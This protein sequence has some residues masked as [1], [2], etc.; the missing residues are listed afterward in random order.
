MCLATF[1]SF[2]CPS[3][4]LLGTQCFLL[5]VGWPDHA[6]IGL[7]SLKLSW[8][9]C[10]LSP[11]SIKRKILIRMTCED[12]DIWPLK[13]RPGML[14]SYTS[15]DIFKNYS[16]VFLLLHWTTFIFS[17]LP[18]IIFIRP[19]KGVVLTIQYPQFLYW[20]SRLNYILFFS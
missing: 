15:Q 9:Q 12:P 17:L 3:L 2:S 19:D 14:I 11:A 18:L 13:D 4:T 8:S 20:K 5:M 7:S 1:C 16:D 6:T 10:I